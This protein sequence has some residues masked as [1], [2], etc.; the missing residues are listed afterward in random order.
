[1]PPHTAPRPP[2]LQPSDRA[3][4]FESRDSDRAPAATQVPPSVPYHHATSVVDG[5]RVRA[6]SG[7]TTSTATPPKLL[8][9]DIALGDSDAEGF[10]NMFDNIGKRTSMFMSVG[11]DKVCPAAVWH[12]SKMLIVIEI[13]VLS[14]CASE[15]T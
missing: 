5:N 2:F 15:R 4:S 14:S 11:E 8:D 3:F 13:S 1:M 10:S 6:F 7:S 12:L 9:S